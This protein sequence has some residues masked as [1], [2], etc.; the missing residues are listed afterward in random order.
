MIARELTISLQALFSTDE[1]TQAWMAAARMPETRALIRRWSKIETIGVTAVVVGIALL[2][3]APFGS[4]AVA[5]WADVTDTDRS[6]LH[7]WIWGITLGTL[8]A[9][10]TASIVVLRF[11]S[12][13]TIDAGSGSA[14]RRS[15]DVPVR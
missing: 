14:A 5:V 2:I 13:G 8:A 9:G 1:Q 12:T 11:S 6:G 3:V 10:T 15:V 4:I 7:W